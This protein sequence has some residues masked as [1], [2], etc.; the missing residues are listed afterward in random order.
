MAVVTAT[1]VY[2]GDCAFCTTCA[3]FIERRIPTRARVIPWQFADLDALGLTQQ[4]CEEAVQWV[5]GSVRASG[6]D[7]IA[8]LLQDAGRFWQIAGSALAVAP[9]RLAA[10][11]AYRWIADHRHLL[12]GG[13]AACS[14]PQAQRDLLFGEN[15]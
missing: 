14:L 7:A 9:V 6:P 11:P 8:L 13:T 15:R 3:E 4:E 10:W 5:A 1:F 2:D 12:P